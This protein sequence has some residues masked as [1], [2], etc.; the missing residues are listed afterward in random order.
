MEE[1]NN[2]CS[3]IKKQG[4]DQMSHANPQDTRPCA[5]N[6]SPSKRKMSR[7][8]SAKKDEATLKK[9]R[10]I[11]EKNHNIPSRL[12]FP[13]ALDLH[14]HQPL[15]QYPS[16]QQNNSPNMISF[17]HHHD[18]DQN[19]GHDQYALQQL[20]EATSPAKVYRGV[21]QRHW[22]KWVAEIRL[23]R[24]RRRLWLGTFESAEEAALAY[25]RQ[26]FRLRGHNARLNFPHRFLPAKTAPPQQEQEAVDNQDAGFIR[27]SNTI[28]INTG[29]GDLETGYRPF[30]DRAITNTDNVLEYSSS[31]ESQW[32]LDSGG[33][34]DHHALINASSHSDNFFQENSL[35]W[36]NINIM[37]LSNHLTIPGD[38]DELFISSIDDARIDSANPWTNEIMPTYI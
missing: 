13:F 30:N 34:R 29:K 28:N 20:S 14:D 12:A 5:L 23:P 6:P 3:N 35:I 1:A 16:P 10:A 24:N 32:V 21:R 15:L 2:F 33:S 9:I 18:Q 11:N 4:D 25:D 26:A 22:G 37:S 38:Q 27:D 19:V 7:I 31:F 17:A 36:H 8:S